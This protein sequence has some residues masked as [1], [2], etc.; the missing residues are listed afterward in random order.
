MSKTKVRLWKLDQINWPTAEHMT[1][2]CKNHRGARYLT[3]NPYT[4]GIHFVRADEE[5]VREWCTRE[6]GEEPS[7]ELVEALAETPT[8]T[9]ECPCDFRDLRVRVEER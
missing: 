9:M 2:T 1:L 4:R 6:G 8:D 3:K 7:K 5:V